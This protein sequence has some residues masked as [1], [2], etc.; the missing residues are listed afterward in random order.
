MPDGVSIGT[1]PGRGAYL[2]ADLACIEQA[3]KRRALERALRTA[4]QEELWTA[5][6]RIINSV[7]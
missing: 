7:S 2:H 6:G 3:R 4:V 1:G 5:L